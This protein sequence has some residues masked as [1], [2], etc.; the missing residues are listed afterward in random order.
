[1]NGND[2]NSAQRQPRACLAAISRLKICQNW[3]LVSSS[4]IM[5]A[6]GLFFWPCWQ[7]DLDWDFV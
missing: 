2:Y 4:D 5:T 1:M 6:E 3:V 7:V